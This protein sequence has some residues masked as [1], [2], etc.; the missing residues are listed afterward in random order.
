MNAH[1]LN[2]SGL[3][4]GMLAIALCLTAAAGQWRLHASSQVAPVA[5]PELQQ[6]IPA[7]FASWREDATAYTQPISAT[8]AAKAGALYTQTLARVYV[9]AEQRRIMLSISYGGQQGDRLQAHR[10]EFCYQAQGFTI[11]TVSDGALETVH[12]HLPLRRLETRRPGRSEPVSYWLTVGDDAALPGLSRKLA[13]FRQ[14]LSGQTA[15]GYLVRISS[16]TESP[17]EAF[18]LHDRFIADL[19]AALPAQDRARLAGRLKS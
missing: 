2:P 5:A 3:R 9:D 17:I 1:A 4:I 16:I 8:D 19:L 18:N 12:G 10:P 14:G 7:R 15:D 11:G 13:Q 6:L